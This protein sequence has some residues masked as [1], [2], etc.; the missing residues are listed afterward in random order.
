M[1][2]CLY[3]GEKISKTIS[4]G[5]LF[6]LE[7]DKY[8]CEK[9]VQAF[10]E[11]KG[12]YCRRC[13]KRCEQECCDDCYKWKVIYDGNDPLHKNISIYHYND[14]MKDVISKWKYRGDYALGDIFK[15]KFQTVFQENF[16]QINKNTL[17]VPI[18]LSEKRLHE[19]NFNQAAQLASFLTTNISPILERTHTEKQSKKS[20]K[21]RLMSKNP[22]LL[23][24]KVQSDVILIDDIYTTGQTVRHAAS[25]LKQNGCTNIY[26]FTLVRG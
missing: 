4:W 7:A 15:Q 18:P 3:C 14:K 9:C 16:S 10:Q 17:I 13:Y 11:I 6:V 19:R 8:S 5:T 12:E 21:E 1:N 20:R 24:E 26:A 22:F 23:R 2:Y 25:L